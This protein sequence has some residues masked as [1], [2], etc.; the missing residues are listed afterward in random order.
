MEHNPGKLSGA[1]SVYIGVGGPLCDTCAGN[2]VYN[3]KGEQVFVCNLE[4]QPKSLIRK[5]LGEKQP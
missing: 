5:Y 4:E 2:A 3:C 1:N